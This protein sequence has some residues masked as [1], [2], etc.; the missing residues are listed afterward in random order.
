[1]YD[2]KIGTAQSWDF[3]RGGPKRGFGPETKSTTYHE[4]KL[5]LECT[6]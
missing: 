2:Q 3:W 5:T 4:I 6:G 1:M